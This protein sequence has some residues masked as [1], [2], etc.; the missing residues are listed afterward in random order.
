M[1]DRSMKI[2]D[3]V[4]ILNVG[5]FGFSKGTI[6]KVVRYCEEFEDVEMYEVEALGTDFKCIHPVK[7]LKVISP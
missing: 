7:D 5:H 3:T 4:E 6:A 1:S 2:G